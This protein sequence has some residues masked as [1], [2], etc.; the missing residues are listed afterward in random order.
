VDA[1]LGE[2]AGLGTSLFWSV[3]SVLF[4][5]SGRRVGAAVVNRVRLL[6]AVVMVSLLHLAI[7]GS[8]LPLDAGLE[9]WGWMGLS[10]LI[11]FVIGDAMLFQAFVMIGPRLSMLLMA[12]APVMGA[13]LAW[14]LLGERL[15]ASEIAGILLALSGVT[16]VVLDRSSS[17]KAG[18]PDMPPRFYALGVLFGL[19]GALGQSGGLIASKVGLEGG[20]PALSGNV[21]RLVVSTI[22][23]WGLAAAS[24]RVRS[25]FTAL[26]EHPRAI[27]LLT[28]AAIFGPVV[29]VWLSLV[30]V[31]NAPV[32]IASTLMS[33]PPI[34]LLPVGH[35]LFKEHITWRAV[36][37]TALAIA[38]TAVIFLST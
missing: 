11:G 32:G 30:A 5:L 38:G 22:A 9:R 7:E 26:R 36:V 27:M 3:S 33:F 21:M 23:I 35:F 15:A 28:T 4:T 14:P 29:G 13:L 24:G 6:L 37:G 19:G 2:L 8:L 1:Y 10:G 34:I 31:Q 12:L 18:L 17:G 25:N 20:F 16:W